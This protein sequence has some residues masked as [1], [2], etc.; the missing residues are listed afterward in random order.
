MSDISHIG[1]L[2]ITGKLA[3]MQTQKIHKQ[4]HNIAFLGFDRIQLLD[5]VGPLEAFDIANKAIDGKPYRCFIISENATFT[6]ESKIKLLSDHTLD[7]TPHIDTLIIP[8]GAGSRVAE[9]TE[10]LK[11]WINQRFDHIER[12]VTVC[13]GLFI[14][15][16]HPYLQ[17]K[18]VVTHWGFAEQFQNLYPQL[19]VNHDRLF[20]Q[21]GKFYSSAGV[22]SG[23]DLA[24]N[25]IEKDH[26]V[27]VAS[28]A[29]KYLVTYLKR[30][31]HQ[32][33]FSESL[34][35]QSTNNDHINRVNRYLESHYS[36]TITVADLAREVHISERHL[37]RLIKTHFHMSASKFIEHNKLEQSKIYLSKQNTPVEVAASMVGYA[38]SDAFRRSFKRKY[39]LAPQSYQLRFQSH[40][41]NQGKNHAQN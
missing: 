39:G 33:Q 37:N 13:T 12:V 11:I 16:D 36:E 8:G 30:S 14:I 6:S 7:N 19:R 4:T 24:L 3:A 27:D 22:L 26:G 25:L 21:Q 18:D 41:I 1:Q 20:L 17:G 2:V 31:G 5:L 35:F 28:Y 40:K 9:I 38:S 10:P 32:S 34:K 23:I 29:A 15:A